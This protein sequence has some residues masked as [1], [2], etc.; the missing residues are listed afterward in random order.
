MYVNY[1]RSILQ[2]SSPQFDREAP[3][4]NISHRLS[5][6]EKIPYHNSTTSTYLKHPRTERRAFDKE[7]ETIC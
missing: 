2:E 5:G 6:L 3:W 7:E 4:M 1:L